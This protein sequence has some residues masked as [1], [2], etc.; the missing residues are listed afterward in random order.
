MKIEITKKQADQFNRMRE[1]L[2]QISKN[3]S[4]PTQLRKESRGEW[5]LD[6]EE[7]I[8]MAYENI[9]GEAKSAVANVKPIT[10]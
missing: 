7:A 1:T 10:I 2:I 3:Y 8:E 5:G 6:F 9:Q 4:T